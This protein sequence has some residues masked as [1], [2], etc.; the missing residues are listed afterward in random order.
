MKAEQELLAIEK[1]LERM[2][3]EL[4]T[5][6]YTVRVIRERRVK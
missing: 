5:M 2:G 6:T 4:L 1:R 3:K